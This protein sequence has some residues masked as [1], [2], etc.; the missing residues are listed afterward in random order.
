MDAVKIRCYVTVTDTFK[1]QEHQDM[2][3]CQCYETKNR[4]KT[5]TTV[6]VDIWLPNNAS[7]TRVEQEKVLRAQCCQCDNNVF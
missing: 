2:H 4:K 1:V 7:K 3:T 5:A 6:I